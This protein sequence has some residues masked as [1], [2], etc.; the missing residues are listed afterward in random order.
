L[1]AFD[2]PR[3]TLADLAAALYPERNAFGLLSEPLAPAP[4][5]LSGLAAAL[6]PQT[7]NAFGLPAGPPTPP[8]SAPDG[9]FGLGVLSQLGLNPLLTPPAASNYLK[10]AVAKAPRKRVFI[11]FQSEDLWA[12]QTLRDI[13]ANEAFDFDIYDESLKRPFD[14]TDAV[15]IRR[16][17]R[18]RIWRSSVTVCLLGAT[19]HTSKWV[20]WELKESLDKGNRIIGMVVPGGPDQLTAP[21]LFRQLG[22]P[23]YQ[24]DLAFLKQEIERAEAPVA[25]S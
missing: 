7:R 14:S 17:I 18:D 4:S 5:A 15:Y 16:G 21:R 22:A 2:P 23:V 6:Y 10:R 19:T 1:N 8:P 9:L 24:W 11:S 25:H 12:V 20:N 3:N 13:A